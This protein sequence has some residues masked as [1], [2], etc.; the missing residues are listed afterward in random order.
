M[1]TRVTAVGRATGIGTTRTDVWNV[2]GTYVF[3]PAPT[4]MSVVSSSASDGVAGTGVQAIE[5]LYLDNNY[6]QLQTTVVL[7]GTTPVLTTP[8]NILRILK[9]FSVAVGSAG[10]AVGNITITGGGNT[11]ARIDA[12]YTASRQCIGTIPANC[13]GFITNVTL[14]GTSTTPN[15]FIEF[16]VRIAALDTMALPGI[17]VT[18][19]TFGISAGNAVSQD[20][21]PPIFVPPQV[22][23][24]VTCRLTVG[25]G[26]GTVAGSVN[27]FLT[28]PLS[29]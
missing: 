19:A 11:Y 4:Q 28:N 15:D 26:V 8:T 12:T 25:S 14:S 6:F 2:G 3:P 22:D 5:I 20:I 23:L 1:G 10:A 29:V 9:V 18:V 17:F 24:K 21:D 13:R 27:G 7:N 16:D